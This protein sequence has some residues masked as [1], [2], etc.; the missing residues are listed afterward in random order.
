MYRDV[1]SRRCIDGRV[2]R[3]RYD[4]IMCDIY[5]REKARIFAN[6]DPPRSSNPRIRRRIEDRGIPPIVTK[7][8]E[9]E[10]TWMV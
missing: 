7:L 1:Y 2:I 3:E 6:V 10:I 8:I 5:A 9:I 4:Y